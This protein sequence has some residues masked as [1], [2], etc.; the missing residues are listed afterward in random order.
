MPQRMMFGALGILL[1]LSAPARAQTPADPAAIVAEG[2]ALVQRPADIAWVQVA[3][4]SRAATSA[5]ARQQAANAMS[6]V[7][8]ALKRSVNDNAIRTSGFS[9]QP[10]MDYQNSPPR[11][12]GYVARNQVEVR[13]DDL[14]KLPAIIDMST[15]GGASSIAGLRFDLKNRAEAEREALRLAVEDGMSRAEAIA[16]GARRSTGPI[17]RIVEQRIFA[18]PVRQQM[19]GMAFAQKAAEPTPILPGEIEIRA[20]VN[21][22][23]AIR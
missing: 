6:A 20:Q 14:D 18:G 11:L 13:V 16:R 3:V 8:A 9:V 12:R 1:L 15:A 22:T 5:A 21:V 7:L 17:I 19:E 10:E 4:E 23:V 2:Q